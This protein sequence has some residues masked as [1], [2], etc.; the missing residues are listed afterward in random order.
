MK[1]TDKKT[2]ASQVILTIELEPSDVEGY[3]E[4]SYKK[5]V[6]KAEIPGF[7][8][9]KAPRPVLESHIGKDE[10]LNDALNSLLPKVCQEVIEE[11]KIIAFAQPTVEVTQT[12]PVVFKAT[13]P[14]PP[15][16]ELGEYG[17][18][19]A[20]PKRATAKKAEVNA[21][22]EQLRRQRA[23]WE[24]V[25]RPVKFDDLVVIDV[26]G[27]ID[28]EPYVNHEGAQYPV[29]RDA[30]YPAP[31][32]AEELI[33]LKRDGEKEFNL[34][35]PKDYPKEKLVGKEAL[36]KVKVIEVKEEKL[37]LLD[38]ELAKGLDPEL[39]TLQA[40][41]QRITSNLKYRAE[42]KAGQE[43]ENE[44]IDAAIKM[45]KVEY[46]PL[47]L[48]MEVDHMIS[49]QMR[50][51]QQTVSSAEEFRQRISQMPAE[52]IREEMRPKTKERVVRS[53]VLGKI[54]AAEKIKVSDKEIK[55]EIE[56]LTKD[57]A[58]EKKEEQL[59]LLNT[60]ENREQLK[61]M[62][63][64]RKTIETLLDKAKGGGPRKKKAS[65]KTKKKEK[66]AK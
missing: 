17:T 65:R 1:V 37:P 45:S 12:E 52:K 61:Q 28:G 15:T 58:A 2:E 59:K 42:E 7:R 63:V 62:L 9:G 26:S 46:P 27:T 8:K 24:P 22:L 43:F 3:L 34:T 44:V 36:F 66:E 48:D 11:Q 49:Q 30:S 32:F 4:K 57:T 55:A 41:R 53:L 38:D 25:E 31:G 23:T 14:L 50:Q 51:L 35:F 10:L 13:V 19:R 33:G 64:M 54:A 60:D 40:L 18:I 39:K 16:V 56:L 5:M 20:K 47:L 21:L 6:Q 29:R